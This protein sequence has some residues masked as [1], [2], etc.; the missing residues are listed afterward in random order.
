MRKIY[1]SE[2]DIKADVEKKLG[3][4]VIELSGTF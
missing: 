3:R 1:H 2:E 4:K